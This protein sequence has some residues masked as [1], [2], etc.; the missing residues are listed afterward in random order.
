MREDERESLWVD[1]ELR[2]FIVYVYVY[3]DLWK[4]RIETNYMES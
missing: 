1:C 4:A 3:K 2:D